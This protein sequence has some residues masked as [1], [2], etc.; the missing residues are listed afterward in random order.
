MSD[1]RLDRI[2]EQAKLLTDVVRQLV[3]LVS[4]VNVEAYMDTTALHHL[5]NERERGFEDVSEELQELR[6]TLETWLARIEANQR[7]RAGPES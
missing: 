4:R 1:P 2:E 6:A 3:I 5:P 7:D